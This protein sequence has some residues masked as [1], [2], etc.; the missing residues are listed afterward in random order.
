[1]QCV[2]FEQRLQQL[3]DD[4]RVVERDEL[5]R[6][7]AGKC[8]ACDALIRSQR[9]LFNAINAHTMY[10]AE[11]SQC[12]S[13]MGVR[14]L[15]QNR[16]DGKSRRKRRLLVA[17]LATAAAL[18]IALLPLAGERIR[19]RENGKQGAGGLA[20]VAPAPQSIA[21]RQLSSQ[22]TED[23]RRLMRQLVVHLSDNR[24]GMLEPVDQLASGIRPLAATFNL[25]F[26]TLRRT[27]PGYSDPQPAQ[28]QAIFQK[29][30][31]SIV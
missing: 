25:A 5:L 10:T 28:P 30:R 31:L 12:P 22:E 9:K 2:K 29:L 27:L 1:M 4:R 6:E 7:H 20:L 8:D 26:D 11:Q 17:A 21:T 3:L 18:M 23:L 16:L 24:F 14:V 15:D 13:D 19:L